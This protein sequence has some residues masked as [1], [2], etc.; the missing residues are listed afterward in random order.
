MQCF[1][2]V[3]LYADHVLLMSTAHDPS[4]KEIS[5]LRWHFW[6]HL[7]VTLPIKL[8]LLCRPW[9]RLLPSNQSRRV[10]NRRIATL[11][12]SRSS[13][14]PS[15]SQLLPL[16]KRNT[17]PHVLLEGQLD[18]ICIFAID[19]IIIPRKERFEN[20]NKRS[21]YFWLRQFVINDGV[22]DVTRNL[23]C[24]TNVVIKGGIL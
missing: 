1:C 17:V 4:V 10:E 18:A 22:S 15:L 24:N 20:K 6:C 14:V 13:S 7:L 16:W 11:V 3:C 8:D 5:A 9:W 23:D 19:I 12:N 21:L 2:A